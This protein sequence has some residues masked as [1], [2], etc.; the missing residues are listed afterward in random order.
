MTLIC[1]KL[2][3]PYAEHL[4]LVGKGIPHRGSPHLISIFEIL[5]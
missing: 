5:I 1:D 4:A 2:K 3:K